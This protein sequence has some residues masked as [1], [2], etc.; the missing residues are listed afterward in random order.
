MIPE[1]RGDYDYDS[2]DEE[3]IPEYINEEN[4]RLN[5]MAKKQK[6]D[7]KNIIKESD[8]LEERHKIIQE[9]AKNVE[10]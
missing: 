2:S 1:E 4:R 7:L 3:E 10:Q 5:I 8:Q 9:H 6:K